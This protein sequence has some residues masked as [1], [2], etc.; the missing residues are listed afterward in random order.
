MCASEYLVETSEQ[1]AEYGVLNLYVLL[2][3]GSPGKEIQE[4]LEEKKRGCRMRGCRS[5]GEDLIELG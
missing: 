1:R 5:I 2:F 3:R 4:G